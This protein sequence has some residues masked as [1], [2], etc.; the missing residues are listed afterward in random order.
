[1]KR[2]GLFRYAPMTRWSVK[3]ALRRTECRIEDAKAALADLTAVWGDVDQGFVNEADERIQ[4]LDRWLAE[5]RESIAE[6]QA[7][8]EAIGP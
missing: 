5:I 8:G 3:L 6:R 7:Y 4:D 2:S 1:M